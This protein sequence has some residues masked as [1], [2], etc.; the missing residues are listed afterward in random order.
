MGVTQ[1]TEAVRATERA[2]SDTAAARKAGAAHKAAIAKRDTSIKAAL[3]TSGVTE[4]GLAAACGLSRSML[5]K[6]RTGR[7]S[8]R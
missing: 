7:K 1:T 2:V 5:N 3:A 6:I 8:Q 4:M